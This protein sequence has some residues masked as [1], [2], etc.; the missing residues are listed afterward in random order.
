LHAVK[1][2]IV[3]PCYNEIGT[4]D[5]PVGLPSSFK[6]RVFDAVPSD[7]LTTFDEVVATVSADA[8]SVATALYVLIE[9]DSVVL[10]QNDPG[11]GPYFCRARLGGVRADY[12]D[13]YAAR[14]A[15]AGD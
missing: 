15:R 11:E 12:S 9:Q 6:R 13:L 7:V 14:V 5:A 10:I 8:V 2:S 3:I 1:L 4:I